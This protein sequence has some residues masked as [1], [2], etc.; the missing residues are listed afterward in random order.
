[1]KEL[2]ACDLDISIEAFDKTNLFWAPANGRRISCTVSA[3]KSV[4]NYIVDRS[5]G[6]ILYKE[7]SPATGAFSEEFAVTAA[8]LAAVDAGAKDISLTEVSSVNSSKNKYTVIL[9]LDGQNVAFA[10][11]DGAVVSSFDINPI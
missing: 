10:V 9:S 3:D 6:E 8:T 7:V 11:I 1:M 4:Y 5:S 2:I